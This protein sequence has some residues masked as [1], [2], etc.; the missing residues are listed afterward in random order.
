MHRPSLALQHCQLKSEQR[1]VL[2]LSQKEILSRWGR[3]LIIGSFKL[4]K[5][6]RPLMFACSYTDLAGC[7]GYKCQGED[8]DL[9]LTSQW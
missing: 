1:V 3:E 5:A 2:P 8:G 6:R 4:G 7:K 9:S